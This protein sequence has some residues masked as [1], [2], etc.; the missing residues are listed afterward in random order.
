MGK[1]PG[2]R[3]AGVDFGSLPPGARSDWLNESNRR[4]HDSLYT[5]DIVGTKPGLLSVFVSSRQANDPLVPNYKLPAVP[6]PTNPNLH[7]RTQQPLGSSHSRHDPN[8]INN[9][10]PSAFSCMSNIAARDIMRTNDIIGGG[11]RQHKAIQ[12]GYDSMQVG[13][14]NSDGV[15]KSGRRGA[16][17]LNPTYQYDPQTHQEKGWDIPGAKPRGFRDLSDNPDLKLKTRD[18][19]GC[20]PDDLTKVTRTVNTRQV[21][22]TDDIYAA[23]ANSV[24]H[25]MRTTRCTNPLDPVYKPL[26]S[27]S[28]ICPVFPNLRDTHK[29]PPQL[30]PS[31]KSHRNDEPAPKTPGTVQR[32]TEKRTKQLT[33]MMQE[34]LDQKGGQMRHQFVKFDQNHDGTINH[35]EFRNGL[36]E[37]LGM[38][39]K[40]PDINLLINHVDR[41]WSG[42]IDYIEFAEKMKEADETQYM[43]LGERG[44][45]D[46]RIKTPAAVHDDMT[47]DERVDRALD[48]KL[49]F[50]V[51]QKC[52]NIIQEF[53]KFDLDGDSMLSRS[54]LKR[55]LERVGVQFTDY[56]FKRLVKRMDNDDTGFV[57]YSEFMKHMEAPELMQKN[58]TG[59]GI[60]NKAFHEAQKEKVPHMLTTL[61]KRDRDIILGIREK[62]DQRAPNV[63]KLMAKFDNDGSGQLDYPEFRRGLEQGLNM[64]MKDEEFNRIVTLFD[65]DYSGQIDYLE[66]SEQ[67]KGKE[68][69][70]EEIYFKPKEE[71]KAPNSKPNSSGGHLSGRRSGRTSGQST[72]KSTRLARAKQRED[73]QC[74]IDSIANL[75]DDLPQASA[76]SA[77]ANVV[78]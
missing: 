42:R 39:I 33:K 73:R 6:A 60:H 77:K 78:G 24:N 51:Q 17:P 66:F 10:R 53:R 3:M 52:A 44:G 36:V 46:F 65:P 26:Q 25:S 4:N 67:I 56:E 41:D 37:G 8:D 43:S 58:G 27:A 9:K 18:I 22:R 7:S 76:V 31:I 1:G 70:R 61:E 48:V 62:A 45:S 14:I 12:K 50:A 23:Q 38:P 74:E 69:G 75:P 16:D 63:R 28:D 20:C 19:L 21:L 2:Q 71:P 13:D 40:T 11:R 5:G 32:E 68:F 30:P 54:E 15:F 47:E 34:R 55:G 35:E 57:D 29:P 72:P 64:V 49:H 59:S